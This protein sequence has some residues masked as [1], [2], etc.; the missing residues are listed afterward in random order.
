MLMEMHSHTSLHSSC[1]QLDPVTL[2]RKAVKKQLQGL[3]ITEH[4]Y[5]W[6]PEE[7]AHLRYDA[8]V[9]DYFVILAAQEVETDI[10]HVLVY[11]PDIT[12]PQRLTLAALRAG[13][14]TA[15]LVWAHPLRDG[16]TP[17]PERL[18][19]PLLDGVEIFSSNHTPQEHYLGL[20]LWHAHKFTALAGSDTHAPETAG[21]LPTQFDHPIRT[22]EELAQEIRH[23]RC[24][25]FFKEAPKP[26]GTGTVQEIVLGTKGEDEVRSRLILKATP[27]EER[28]RR[29]Q[30]S[31][32]ITQAVHAVGFDGG[33]LRV[34]R[35]VA[36]DEGARLIIEEGQRGRS[37]FDLLIQVR[38]EVGTV[39]FRLAARWLAELHRRRL[40]T[41]AGPEAVKRE[42][43]RFSSYLAAFLSTKSPH[44]PA[45]KTMVEAVQAHEEQ[46]FAARPGDF[47][48]LHGD[49]HPKNI[50][51]GQDRMQDP[52][53]LYISVIDFANAMEFVPA[54]D[55]G[56]FLAQFAYQLREYPQIRGYYPAR[57]FLI[58]YGAT[59]GQAVSAEWQREVDLFR[60]R[61]N[62]S[63]AAFLI[64]LGK[65]VS[66]DMDDL[67]RESLALL[68]AA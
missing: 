9:E 19:S 25:P 63:I 14:P 61:A 42:R 43:W 26:G 45:A 46:I 57:D 66:P 24:R 31:A 22:V 11:G 64:K 36:I 29:A 44:L 60:V 38:P 59:L 2:V 7:I 58:T 67:V 32:R 37:L 15:A 21:T 28:W 34:P 47:I 3:V 35:I 54:F 12:I 50:I 6:T 18:L 10:G 40:R 39:Y 56:Y 17:A 52:S 55:V 62:L 16:R 33:E 1:S 53:T 8:E 5:L 41:G 27:G 20:K 49:Y 30:A 51:I 68:E 65:G 48:Q 4:H 23:G 13:F